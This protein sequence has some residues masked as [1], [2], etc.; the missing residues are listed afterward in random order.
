MAAAAG[1]AGGGGGGAAAGAAVATEDVVTSVWATNLNSGANVRAALG[2]G[3]AIAGRV[4]ARSDVG[5]SFILFADY[6]SAVTLTTLTVKA[7]DADLAPTRIKL[8]VNRRD[9]GFDDAEE[10]AAE[11]RI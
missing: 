3:G 11:V 4:S 9:F 6:R 2:L 5:N 1:G 8:F 7:P 10:P